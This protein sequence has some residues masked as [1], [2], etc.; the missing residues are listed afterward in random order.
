[1]PVLHQFCP[2]LRPG[3]AI[4]N[5]AVAIHRIAQKLGLVSQAWH[6]YAGTHPDLPSRPYQHCHFAP[7]DKL[8]LHYSTASDLDE[9]VR[10][11]AQ[12]L[13]VC[14]HN[15]TPPEYYAPFNSSLARHLCIGRERLRDHFFGA[16]HFYA[17][18]AFN[19]A[20]LESWGYT[21]IGDLPYAISP[22]KLIAAAQQSSNQARIVQ[23]REKVNWLF[24]GRIAPNKRQDAIVQALARYRQRFQ[25][26]ARLILLG[27]AQSAGGY[28]RYVRAT[29]AALGVQE[30]VLI[31]TPSDDALSAYY[32][33]ADVFVSLSEHEGF[34]VPLVEAMWMGVPI[35]ALARAA[36][37]ETMGNAGVL[38]ESNQPDLVAACVHTVLTQPALRESIL[39]AQHQQATSFLLDPSESSIR[40]MLMGKRTEDGGR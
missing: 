34:G 33:A 22:D 26:N 1:M 6:V 17:G 35:V 29:I 20:E 32:A 40:Q 14:Y 21:Q 16:A 8:L 7:G 25:P 13:S 10:P 19:R 18:T 28:E 9:F 38:L 4:S 5:Q 30:H 31:D 15:I 11:Y 37:P 36:V 24:V 2:V 3:D 12:Q 23:L 27:S 39:R